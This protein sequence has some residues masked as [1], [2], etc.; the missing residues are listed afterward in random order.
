MYVCL[1]VQ[2]TTRE[3]VEPHSSSRLNTLTPSSTFVN[4]HLLLPLPTLGYFN[5]P[6]PLPPPPPWG[7]GQ[8]LSASP[9]PA[10]Y[11]HMTPN[12]LH[13]RS[14]TRR[15]AAANLHEHYLSF[16]PG[17]IFTNKPNLPPPLILG[18]GSLSGEHMYCTT[19]PGEAV[20]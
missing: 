7:G 8:C 9:Y 5:N 14:E 6:T 2:G 3:I 10:N 4:I 16:C 18:W 1:C 15:T 13:N 17:S 19:A 20:V 11:R 12:S